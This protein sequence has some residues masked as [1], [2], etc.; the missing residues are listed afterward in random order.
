MMDE[1]DIIS[2][3][4]SIFA[5]GIASIFSII[6]G[7]LQRKSYRASMLLKAYDELSTNELPKLLFCL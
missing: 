4:V 7:L 2:V 1:S 6:G 5:I 3:I